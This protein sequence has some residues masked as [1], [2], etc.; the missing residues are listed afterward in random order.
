[1]PEMERVHRKYQKWPSLRPL[2][3]K[4][5][6]IQ[7]FT[8]SENSGDMN[9]HVLKIFIFFYLFILPHHKYNENSKR[10]NIKNGFNNGEETQ[11]KL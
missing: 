3:L 2:E 6:F 7:Q 5:K 11:R 9:V 8:F 4:S 10:K 1:M